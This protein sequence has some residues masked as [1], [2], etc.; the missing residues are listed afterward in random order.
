M[1]FRQADAGEPPR[2]FSV[3]FGPARLHSAFGG[4]TDVPDT[5]KRISWTTLLCILPV[6]LLAQ[7][8]AS[9]QRAEMKKLDW[10][11]GQWKGGGWIQMAPQ[12]RKEFTEAETVQSK[13]DGLVFLIDGQG[14]SKAR[15]KNR[16]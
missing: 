13:L 10:L 14:K 3:A 2:L 4:N 11:V 12:G 7:A 9:G 16:G 8:P 1:R 5:M 15:D 6:A